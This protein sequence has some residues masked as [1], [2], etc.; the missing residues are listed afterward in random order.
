MRRAFVAGAAAAL[1][2]SGIV[3][4]SHSAEAAYSQCLSGQAC[5]WRDADYVG[6]LLIGVSS[7]TRNF[8][9]ASNDQASSLANR[10][11]RQVGWYTDG[12]LQGS[13]LCIQ[14]FSNSS[15]VSNTYNDKISSVIVYPSGSGYC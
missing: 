5:A 14:P 1:A 2:V 6:G 11:S 7:G 3:G 12:S 8:E 13:R 9:N 15:W 10:T 4:T